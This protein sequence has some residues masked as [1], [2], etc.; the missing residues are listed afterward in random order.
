MKTLQDMMAT[1]KLTDIEVKSIGEHL[2]KDDLLPVYAS[3]IKGERV[4][5]LGTVSNLERGGR[6]VFETFV[7]TYGMMGA[8]RMAQWLS[9]NPNVTRKNLTAYYDFCDEQAKKPVY[10]ALQPANNVEAYFKAHHEG[11][12]MTTRLL[13]SDLGKARIAFARD[14]VG[15]EALQ[16]RVALERF[17][18]TKG[19]YPKDIAAVVPAYIEK[20]PPDPFSGKPYRYRLDADGHFLFWSVGED[21]KDD[22]GKGDPKR[23]WDGP[24]YVFTSRP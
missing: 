8:L 14:Q 23:F 4:A 10:E 16:L 1:G 5:G 21:L 22:G 18:L 20:L 3:A 12:D 19:V 6:K 15:L 11:W 9:F 13:V 2:A 24:D 17:R 7:K